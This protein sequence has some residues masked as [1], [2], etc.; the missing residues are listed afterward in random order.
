LQLESIAGIG[1]RHREMVRRII[2][3]REIKRLELDI[4]ELT[5][6]IKGK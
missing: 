2:I 6:T 4:A 5:Q 1:I 3:Q